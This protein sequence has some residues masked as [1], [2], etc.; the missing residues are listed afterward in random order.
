MS[1]YS[2]WLS[3][4][5]TLLTN[6]ITEAYNNRNAGNNLATAWAAL[7][8]DPNVSPLLP[9]GTDAKNKFFAINGGPTASESDITT[10]QSWL[11]QNP[12]EAGF[13]NLSAEVTASNNNS[14]E[15]IG[16]GGN[17][18]SEKRR[19]KGQPL[20]T[21]GNGILVGKNEKLVAAIGTEGGTDLDGFGTD[22]LTY[23]DG[24]P[25]SK[26]TNVAGTTVFAGDVVVSGSI[27][28]NGGVVIIDDVIQLERGYSDPAGIG[29]NDAG[30]ILLRHRGEG[31]LDLV[32]EDERIK[33]EAIDTTKNWV[34]SQ[35]R[36]AARYGSSLI[37]NSSFEIKET[38]GSTEAGNYAERPAGVVSIGTATSD[39]AYPQEGIVS[40]N[41]NGRGI[42]FPAVA[43]EGSKFAIRIRFAGDAV[44]TPSTDGTEQGL[45]LAMYE[46]SDDNL[47]GKQYVYQTGGSANPSVTVE[48]GI[49]AHADNV[50]I[51]LLNATADGAVFD[52]SAI[53]ISS[54]TWSQLTFSYEPTAGTNFASFGVFGKN[55]ASNNIYIDFVVMTPV[56]VD[57][58]A[59]QLEVQ[60]AVSNITAESEDSLVP[61]AQMNN[62]SK[63]AAWNSATINPTLLA[64]DAG[65]TDKAIGFE[66]PAAAA[67][68]LIS[69]KIDCNN[70]T[71]VI[72][73]RLKAINAPAT[74]RVKVLENPTEMYNSTVDDTTP[75]DPT[76]VAGGYS[77]KN[78]TLTKLDSDNK[79]T[80][81]A[82]QTIDLATDTWTTIIGTYEAG[83][84]SSISSSSGVDATVNRPSEFS[85]WLQCD[86][87]A[88]TISV[89]YVYAKAQTT[90]LNI[91]QTLASAAY[92]DAEG[93]VTEI[94]DLLV[95]E[96]GSLITNASMALPDSSG[97][98]AGYR[99]DG[100]NAV[101]TREDTSGDKSIRV[102]ADSGTRTL[103]TPTFKMDTAD[104]Y[105]VGL[106][107][108]GHG[109]SANVKLKVAYINGDLEA[110][111]VTI[112]PDTYTTLAADVQTTYT[113]GGV[114][115]DVELTSALIID[116]GNAEGGVDNTD[117]NVGTDYENILVTWSKPAGTWTT[118]AIVIESDG[119]FE[120]DYVLVKEQVVSFSL[121][122][123][124]AVQRRGEA[125]DAAVN[126]SESVQSNMTQEA[127]SLLPNAA[128]A[129]FE[130]ISDT[131]QRPTGFVGTRGTDEVRRIIK[132]A[133]GNIATQDTEAVADV[134]Q[135]GDAISFRSTGTGAS[136]DE[137]YGLLCP[138]VT[139]GISPAAVNGISPSNNGRYSFVARVRASAEEPI[140]I[141][142]VAHE[143]FVQLGGDKSH[144]MEAG[145][146]GT[147]GVETAY[148][149]VI[150]TFTTGAGATGATQ[151][152]QIINITNSLDSQ[153]GT[154]TIDNFTEIIPV[155]TGEADGDTDDTADNYETWYDIG[156]TYT[157][158]S[159]TKLVCFEILVNSDIDDD[160]EEAT[161]PQKTAHPYVDYIYF[162][163]QV[164]DADFADSLAN[165]RK[166]ELINNEIASLESQVSQMQ[167]DIG[168]INAAVEVEDE[169]Q[170]LIKN[171]TFGEFFDDS[172]VD[173]LKNWQSTRTSQNK[174][175]VYAQGNDSIGTYV[176][177]YDTTGDAD[178][179]I[180]MLS[181]AMD[182]PVNAVVSY[183][184]QDQISSIGR[185][186]VVVRC[187]GLNSGATLPFN[188]QIIAHEQFTG[189]NSSTTTHVIDS[190]VPYTTAHASSL[191]SIGTFTNNNTSGK[192][193][194]LTTIDL[195]NN[196][197]TA[198]TEQAVTTDLTAWR[199]ILATYTPDPRAEAVSF[200]FLFDVD[201]DTDTNDAEI[202]V[203]S[204]YLAIS[205]TPYDVAYS[206]SDTRGLAAENTAALDATD[207]ANAAETAAQAQAA[208]LAAAASSYAVTEAA[209]INNATKSEQGSIMYNAGFSYSETVGSSVSETFTGSGLDD[210]SVA[211]SSASRAGTYKVEIDST[212]EKGV[213][214]FKYYIDNVLQAE[215]IP[216][217]A[218]KEA[219]LGPFGP[220]VT[221]AASTGHAIGEYWTVP[222]VLHERP[223]LYRIAGTGFSDANAPKNLRYFTLP[224]SGDAVIEVA[225][226]VAGG[227]DSG[228]SEIS[229]LCPPVNTPADGQSTNYSIAVK[230]KSSTADTIGVDLRVHELYTY[231]HEH[232]GKATFV[233]NTVG[234]GAVTITGDHDN[235]INTIDTAVTFTGPTGSGWSASDIE[236]DVHL[237]TPHDATLT[238]AVGRFESP[239]VVP[240]GRVSDVI[241]T[242]LSDVNDTTTED[243]SVS[244]TYKVIGGNFT[245]SADT[246]QF[247]IEI[248][249]TSI[250]N[251]GSYYVDYI[252]VA[253]S[254]I[255]PEA[256]QDLADARALI[257]ADERIDVLRGG[258]SGTLNDIDAA[259]TAVENNIE[260]EDPSASAIPNSTFVQTWEDSG[261]NYAKGWVATLGDQNKITV[262]DQGNGSIGTYIKPY[263]TYV[264]GG[265][266]ATGILSKLIRNPAAAVTVYNASTN[267]TT[268]GS[269]NVAIRCRGVSSSGNADYSVQIRAHEYLGGIAENVTHIYKDN[270][271]NPLTDAQLG[272]VILD[273]TDGS[274]G[275]YTRLNTVDLSLESP[276]SAETTQVT[277]NLADWRNI[278]GTYTPSS[279][280]V[281]AVSFEFYFN[282]DLDGNNVI[283]QIL[284]DSVYMDISATPVSIVQ[285]IGDTAQ[286]NAE[287]TAESYT[288]QQKDLIE[289]E[290]NNLFTSFSDESGSLVPNNTFTSTV[291]LSDLYAGAPD[292]VRPAKGYCLYRYPNV[293]S[294]G[295]GHGGATDRKQY[296]T[297]D[298]TSTP[299]NK[300]LRIQESSQENDY[301]FSLL[302]PAVQL[303]PNGAFTV[304]VKL[305]HESTD[306]NV[307]VQIRAHQFF[308]DWDSTTYT[309]VAAGTS[310]L[311]YTI[312]GIDYDHVSDHLI[313]DHQSEPA[314][315]LFRP[316]DFRITKANYGE[317]STSTGE[318]EGC[319]TDLLLIQV[320]NDADTAAVTTK[321]IPQSSVGYA[322]FGGSFLV[323][324]NASCVSLEIF[325]D[326]VNNN[327]AVL[328]DAITMLNDTTPEINFAEG[329]Q[330]TRL[331]SLAE[332]LEAEEDDEDEVENILLNP[333]GIN[334]RSVRKVYFG[335][336]T[337][338]LYPQAWRYW[339]MGDQDSI[340]YRVGGTMVNVP[341]K[342]KKMS[343]KSSNESASIT[344]GY[345]N[346]GIVSKPFRIK[347]SDYEI[348][349]KLA[350]KGGNITNY[351]NVFVMIVEYDTVANPKWINPNQ[352]TGY[353]QNDTRDADIK[354]VSGYQNATRTINMLSTNS[355][356]GGTSSTSNWALGY[357]GN[358]AV[359]DDA[360]SD[361]IWYVDDVGQTTSHSYRPADNNSHVITAAYEPTSTAKWAALVIGIIDTNP[362]YIDFDYLKIFADP[363][364]TLGTKYTKTTGL[365]GLGDDIF[366]A[367]LR[368]SAVDK[369]HVG[370]GSV[371]NLSAANM[372]RSG[373]AIGR[374]Y[375]KL[376]NYTLSL[377]RL[378][379]IGGGS[380]TSPEKATLD[381]DQA[382]IA[383]GHEFREA[384]NSFSSWMVSGNSA[385]NTHYMNYQKTTPY[386]AVSSTTSGGAISYVP[387]NINV[388]GGIVY[389]G[390]PKYYYTSSSSNV[391]A[392]VS[393]YAPKT[394]NHIG[395][396]SDGEGMWIKPDSDGAGGIY[397]FDFAST[398]DWR[399][400]H[401]SS[402]NF[403]FSYDNSAK[404][405]MSSSSSGGQ[406][407]F[408]GQH[409]CED[410]EN[411]LSDSDVG[412]IVV[413]TGKYN[414]LVGSDKPTINESLP[415]VELSSKRNQ[416]SCFGVLSDKEDR[417]GKPREYSFGRFVSAYDDDEELDRL[418]IN[419]L[420]EGGIW[421]CNING[422]FENGD[423]ITT[424]EVPG[425]GMLQDD[426]LLHNYTVAK[427]TQDCTFELDNPN[428]DC[429]E[430]EHEGQTYRKAFVGCTYHC[431]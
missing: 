107:V 368:N 295:T 169:N 396:T 271:A 263:N 5:R 285:S 83:N 332:E 364:K 213:D 419:S 427:I 208:I 31:F 12:T 35:N 97:K 77:T 270:L 268:I 212:D 354:G 397:F 378:F 267:T 128:F 257:K 32:A 237:F 260:E 122:D 374:S 211:I 296:L 370:L 24:V 222:V 330:E 250:Q 290:R 71:Y 20:Y 191:V 223:V 282:A 314:T 183:S 162:A 319:V 227:F 206:I 57:I 289:E 299:T 235:D 220:A 401:S 348:D 386:S 91:A 42:L 329:L 167:V 357:S 347:N 96:S 168:N 200:E 129:A 34:G 344:S 335:S 253:P 53:P 403:V 152:L 294:G 28:G 63:W 311:D 113:V 415:V 384:D 121:A 101:L 193:T 385:Y 112:A 413:S 69:S 178:N 242:T 126:L 249:G 373:A 315:Q 308:G 98:P 303:A 14:Q 156:G 356:T 337:T 325:V 202:L 361:K 149:S 7:S 6:A 181:K 205:S 99:A 106:T 94:N 84:A 109:G 272:A 120:V 170:S 43:I 55:L 298:A 362:W 39:L 15:D 366:P 103:I 185:Y 372:T 390:T 186:N 164:V 292:T 239:A 277:T 238:K 333:M 157:A 132:T 400:Y 154:S 218:G 23:F 47:E 45:F 307:T 301:D 431:G 369:N 146:F 40:F 137:E 355:G 287:S 80:G 21:F 367:G 216:I 392:G 117:W 159:S 291:K 240:E 297:Y 104:K 16:G 100:S 111:K 426:D 309:T 252:H 33:N 352:W 180:G 420:G 358:T 302:T 318:P 58:S 17:V 116:D 73:Y 283:Q 173:Y 322:T 1:S 323:H 38:S 422:N 25:F 163:P 391:K 398:N 70:D 3:T 148:S 67:G 429:V 286:S 51:N 404:A 171:S 342:V 376:G 399:I 414:N 209:S 204:V 265:E 236:S 88:A 29:V 326:N 182:T 18:G 85:L 127:G 189:Y 89:D 387:G 143:S 246:K 8:G 76:Y 61:D 281:S 142:I 4:N 393:Y 214:S 406:I 119:D 317:Q 13:L 79:P 346:H 194:E 199:N 144:V 192:S 264:G 327:T 408:T 217:V 176:K 226:N 30:Q 232:S 278:L 125:M 141:K 207:K 221:F 241:V 334:S 365:S 36:N 9:D 331:M 363:S 231:I 411:S 10:I 254:T 338:K 41:G 68:G 305:K 416:K 82:S 49:S 269:Y 19:W 310:G 405:W 160:N 255:G 306:T 274:T 139:L 228:T 50:T 81:T 247:V 150:Q 288:D 188:V 383:D 379:T 123:S 131:Y 56:T 92:A 219:P 138:P 259:I 304:A 360:N 59:V 428:Y 418:I 339:G 245:A 210:L 87:Q 248:V 261:V 394:S 44:T 201:P 276:V 78:I 172:G 114:T 22:T 256:A 74:V 134:G 54:G 115:S 93:F 197:S 402:Q 233:A 409:R 75:L 345:Y 195:Y 244:T 351:A 349:I 136:L 64:G 266:E 389:A 320:D 110:G 421:I 90:S 262:F 11:T 48:T 424:C 165:A 108:K 316:S 321:T 27:Q 375:A 177:P 407:N 380:V 340:G 72:G 155:D 343:I 300:V 273:Y 26:G 388:Y 86:T 417:N 174:I 37:P 190:T 224:S 425:Y 313:A 52:G 234:A 312:S 225:E 66:T 95:K 65:G 124:Q 166:Q 395:L 336:M 341:K 62:I 135:N 151:D 147:H 184:E 215:R 371:P 118:G 412:L 229:L 175:R 279:A 258:Y 353:S 187:R 130:I 2:D 102:V 60:G 203:D 359:L 198:S 324:P 153:P 275:T 140:S 158:N 230:V 161:S 179:H 410:L 145:A 196:S 105:S 377:T 430:F 423:Y 350:V 382:A 243:E 284:V 280:D 46:T 133:S 293:G 251:G 381:L 328:I